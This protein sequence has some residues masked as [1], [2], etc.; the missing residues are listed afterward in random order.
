MVKAPS[1]ETDFSYRASRDRKVF[2]Y[3]RGRQVVTL[4]GRKAVAFLDRVDGLDEQAAQLVMAKVTD[5][6]KRGNER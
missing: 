4:Q 1:E 3:W 6:F 5:N 2:L